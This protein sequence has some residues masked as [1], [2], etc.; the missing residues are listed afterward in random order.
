MVSVTFSVFSSQ[1]LALNFHRHGQWW[2]TF[3]F[4]VTPG[5]VPKIDIEAKYTRLKEIA[6][7]NKSWVTLLYHQKNILKTRNLFWTL[8]RFMVQHLSSLSGISMH[9]DRKQSNFCIFHPVTDRIWILLNIMQHNT[10]SVL[11]EAWR[12]A[13]IFCYYFCDLYGFCLSSHLDLYQVENSFLI[14]KLIWL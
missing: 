12:D 7:C 3:I 10:I 4:H 14:S 11:D 13:D 1:S 2:R 5:G 6:V 9:N 8:K